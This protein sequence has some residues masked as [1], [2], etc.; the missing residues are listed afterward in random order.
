MLLLYKTIEVENEGA[1]IKLATSFKKD[2]FQ[3]FEFF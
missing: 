1:Y 2:L 3:F